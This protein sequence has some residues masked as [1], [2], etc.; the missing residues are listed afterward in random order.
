MSSS[1]IDHFDA[2]IRRQALEQASAGDFPEAQ[3]I[4]NVHAHTFFS[5]KLLV[6]PLGEPLEKLL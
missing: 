2:T 3:S 5:Y 1:A 4:V 6:F